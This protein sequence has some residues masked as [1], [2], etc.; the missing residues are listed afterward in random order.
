MYIRRK[1]FSL[2]QD[3]TGEER[4]FSTTE[5]EDERLYT[6]RN[7]P[8]KVKRKRDHAR[9]E[10]KRLRKEQQ[11]KD[12]LGEQRS[13]IYDT[14]AKEESGSLQSLHDLKANIENSSAGNAIDNATM[15]NS[16]ATNTI[17]EGGKGKLRSWAKKTSKKVG[18]YTK[19]A[20]N[21]EVGKLGK[22]G[23]RALMIGA[24]V[25]ATGTPIVAKVIKSK[26]NDK[27]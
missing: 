24:P 19:K 7:N 21:G 9:A 20:W 8:K 25:V 12:S 23:N 5:F 17:K 22:T 11:L 6:S 3:E 27:N 1:V 2:L 18:N 26:H 14:I 16:S 10:R 15:N 4:Y 13:T